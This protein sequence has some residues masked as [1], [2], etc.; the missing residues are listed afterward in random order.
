VDNPVTEKEALEMLKDLGQEV[1]RLFDNELGNTV[2]V[3]V[4]LWD[5]A[6]TGRFDYFRLT[7][8]GPGSVHEGFYTRCE[9][10]QVRNALTEALS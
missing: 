3:I 1:E 2:R 10:E 5:R 9:V 6:P 7:I 4:S 8:E